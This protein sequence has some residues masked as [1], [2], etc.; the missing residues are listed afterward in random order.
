[1]AF[2][3]VPLGNCLFLRIF[4]MCLH[5]NLFG[6][7]IPDNVL[8]SCSLHLSHISTSLAKLLGQSGWNLAATFW[9]WLV[10][11]IAKLV[12]VMW[13]EI[14]ENGRLSKFL[15]KSSPNPPVRMLPN[16]GYNVRPGSG[17]WIVEVMP[18][19]WPEMC[20]NGGLRKFL[21]KLCKF[22]QKSSSPAPPVR[23]LP[24]L[25]CNVR[26]GH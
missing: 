4:D 6:F 26:P 20:Q 13:L 25:G 21:G 23:M 1:M 5:F 22:F 10:T 9:S 19:M 18:I 8:S 14:G 16:L 24:N 3:P 12:L 17:C 15:Q 2:R 11:G 7:G